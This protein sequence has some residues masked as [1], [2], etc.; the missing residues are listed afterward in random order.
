MKGSRAEVAMM[1]MKG[2]GQLGCILDIES[3]DLLMD[4]M[5]EEGR[6]KDS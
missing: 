5:W 1:T 6:V 2:Y 4:G 3:T